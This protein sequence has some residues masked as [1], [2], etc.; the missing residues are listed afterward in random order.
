[1]KNILIERGLLKR[2]GRPIASDSDV[3]LALGLRLEKIGLVFRYVAYVVLAGIFLAGFAVGSY[4][5][6]AVITVVVLL[7]AAFVHTVLLTHRYEWF[8][9]PFNFAIHVAEISCVV[10]FTGAEESEFFTL[11]LLFLV[12]YTVYRR[13]FG[14]MLLASAV[15]CGAYL[16][17]IAI[18]WALAGLALPPGVIFVKV[19]SIPVCGWIVAT[20]N[21]LLQHT[22]EALEARADALASSETMLRTIIDHAAEPILVYDENEFIAEANNRAC[23]FFGIFREN[24]LG[25]PFRSLLFDD[26]TLSE[27]LAALYERNEYHGE[28]IFLNADGIERTVDLHVRSFIR[29]ARKFFVAIARDITEQKELQEATQLANARLGHLNRELRQVNELKTGLL[30]SVSQRLRS[31]LTALLGYLDLLLDDE[32]GATTPEQ[33][34]ALLG[35]RRSV[36]RIFGLL[37]EAFDSKS[38]RTDAAL[39]PEAPPRPVAP[40]SAQR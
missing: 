24:L 19:A 39:A 35:G 10:F 31:P 34:R 17:V 23:E 13:S 33:R 40:P 38:L 37:D 9:S 20:T 36:M 4:T 27:Q 30:T 26:G 3:R 5:D 6:L 1:M 11:Y 21:T 22:E 16:L 12:G 32:L 28:Q 25:K 8:A 18:E 14:G 29:N 2:G 15:T 7:H